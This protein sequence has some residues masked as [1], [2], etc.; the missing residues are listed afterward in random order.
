MCE[1][2]AGAPVASAINEGCKADVAKL[3]ERGVTPKLAIARFGEREDDVAYER[4]AVK[5]CETVGVLT[6]CVSLPGGTEGMLEAIDALNA[7]PSVH[8]ILLFRPLP[9]SIDESAVCERVSVEKDADG[10]TSRSLTGVFTGRG[11]GFA[12]CTAQACVEV[13]DHY[14]IPIEGKRAVIVGRSLVVGKPA[15]MLLLA[16][17]A[18]VAICHKS[19]SDL[20]AECRGADILIVAAGQMGLIDESYLTPGQYVIDVGI[21]V[22]DDGSMRG[23]VAVDYAAAPVRGITPVPG[24]VGTVTT[25]LLVRN[26]VTA[27][28]RSLQ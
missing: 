14:G 8:G 24:G 2:L 26:T 27:A 13:L 23:D 11:E 3:A 20:R 21:H 7:D 9:K 28:M 6:Q 4:A 16:R 5:R 25:S 19:T 17:N 1:R 22:A 15:A 12:P 10:I 18:T